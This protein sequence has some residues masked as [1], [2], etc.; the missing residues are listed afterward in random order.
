MIFAATDYIPEAG[1]EA[2][3]FFEVAFQSDRYPASNNASN[4]GSKLFLLLKN[5]VNL[6]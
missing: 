2:G 6:S 3:I 5:K 4:N 1:V